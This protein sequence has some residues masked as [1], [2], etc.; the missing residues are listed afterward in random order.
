MAY[1]FTNISVLIVDSQPPLIELIRGVLQMFRVQKIYVAHDGEKARKLFHETKPDLLIVDWQ[2]VDMNGL[3]F[4]KT[5]R[6]SPENPF[7]PIIFMTAFTSIQRVTE[8]RDSGITEFMAKPFTVRSL[9][10]RIETI[11]ERP[12][13]FVLTLDYRGPDRR[14]KRDESYQS[15][16]RR[17]PSKEQDL[18]TAEMGVFKTQKKLRDAKFVTPPNVMKQKMGSGGIDTN[19]LAMAQK[20]LKS[21]T[22][23]F[24]PIGIALVNALDEGLQNSKTGNV[25]SE[26]AIEFMLYPSVQLKAQGDLF[27]YPLVTRIADILVNFLE[28]VEGT[29]K[30]VFEIVESHITAITFV[31]MNNITDDGGAHGKE[32]RESLIDVCDRYYKTRNL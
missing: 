8:A 7:V 15:V 28:T 6:S 32:L 17:A 10:E 25:S 18:I 2:L 26:A 20:S 27:H 24:K 21:N 19:A 13:Q 23:N 16:E 4:A 30:D 22:V 12:R 9:S 11:V 29:D 1:K 14:R 3:D 5:I 31:L